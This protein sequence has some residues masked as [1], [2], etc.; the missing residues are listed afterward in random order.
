ML[1]LFRPYPLLPIQSWDQYVG[2]MF[3]S[4]YPVDDLEEEYR[5]VSMDSI[6]LRDTQEQIELWTTGAATLPGPERAP[7]VEEA[8]ICYGTV[9]HTLIGSYCHEDRRVD[10]YPASV[11]ELLHIDQ[12][13]HPDISDITRSLVV[14]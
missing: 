11:R 5:A 8:Y 9:S 2:D 12:L 3:S 10:D 4:E 13:L 6:A 14:R 7:S 1:N